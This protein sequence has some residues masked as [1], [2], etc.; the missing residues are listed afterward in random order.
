MTVIW[1]WALS[2]QNEKLDSA[3]NPLPKII[4]FLGWVSGLFPL[5]L[6]TSNLLK[7]LAPFSQQIFL[8]LISFLLQHEQQAQYEVRLTRSRVF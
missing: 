1:S 6:R 4:H 8:S 3:D 5:Y 7:L 2:F